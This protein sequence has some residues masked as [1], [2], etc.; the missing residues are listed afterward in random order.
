[1]WK[2]ILSI[3]SGIGS[4]FISN[5][6]IRNK[7]FDY[8]GFVVDSIVN[9]TLFFVDDKWGIDDGENIRGVVSDKINSKRG[10]KALKITTRNS[11]I[12]QTTNTT[13]NIYNQEKNKTPLRNLTKIKTNQ[14]PLP[15]LMLAKQKSYFI[16]I[17]T[18]ASGFFS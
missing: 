14:T 5:V 16:P 6:D 10:Q 13:L 15:Y 17:P 7:Q 18:W 2:K 11:V 9:T 4:A 12:N 3:V 8:Q 1:M